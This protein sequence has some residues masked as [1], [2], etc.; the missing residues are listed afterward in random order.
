M[1]EET[2]EKLE[3]NVSDDATWEVMVELHDRFIKRNLE[4]KAYVQDGSI[5]KS[6]IL[7]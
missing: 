5:D 6:K 2:R 1:E 7:K 4:D 3:G